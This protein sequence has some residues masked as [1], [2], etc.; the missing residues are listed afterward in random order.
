MARVAAPWRAWWPVGARE[1]LPRLLLRVREAG[2][3]GVNVHR[4]G[5]LAD[6]TGEWPGR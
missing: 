2:A 5:T 1:A 4:A 6:P 3:G